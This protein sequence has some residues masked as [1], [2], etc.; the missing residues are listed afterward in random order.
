MQQINKLWRLVLVAALLAGAL[1]LS[2]VPATPARAIA[3]TI[4][5]TNFNTVSQR[6]EER[7]VGKEC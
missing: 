4:A 7:R 5:L 2:L 1:N 6:S 3:S